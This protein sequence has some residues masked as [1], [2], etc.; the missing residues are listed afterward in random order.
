MAEKKYKDF[1]LAANDINVGTWVFKSA[2]VESNILQG[3]TA[4]TRTGNKIYVHSIEWFICCTPI[5]TMPTSGTQLRLFTYHNKDTN[6]VLA[7]GVQVFNTDSIITLRNTDFKQ[8]YVLSNEHMMSFVPTATNAATVSAVG[9]VQ[10]VRIMQYV[11]KNIQ[12]TATTAN[13][14][15]LLTDDYG[16]CYCAGNWS[17]VAINIAYK[18]KILFSDA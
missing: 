11:K 5:V 18:A 16:L 12:F 8:K 10:C 4:S 6:G 14:A 15:D 7:T 13:I 1:L 2:L 17:P 9:P 3:V